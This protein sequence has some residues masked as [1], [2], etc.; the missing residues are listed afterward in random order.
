MQAKIFKD[1]VNKHFMN[2]IH[3]CPGC[4]NHWFI[5]TSDLI[6]PYH[7]RLCG[8]SLDLVQRQKENPSQ[9]NSLRL[10]RDLQE[11]KNAA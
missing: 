10:S 11:E 8:S 6:E 2:F 3:Q 5:N 1:K 9:F 7:C 4:G